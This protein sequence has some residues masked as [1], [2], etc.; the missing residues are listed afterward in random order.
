MYGIERDELLYSTDLMKKEQ[1]KCR[2]LSS[3]SISGGPRLTAGQSTLAG[4]VESGLQERGVHPVT[5]LVSIE[6]AHCAQQ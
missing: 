1:N 6:N 5:G 2:L 4:S 3:E